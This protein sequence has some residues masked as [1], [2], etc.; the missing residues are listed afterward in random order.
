MDFLHYL[1]TR[2]II[3]E[4][5][6]QKIAGSAAQAGTDVLELLVK[7]GIDK[8]NVLSLKGEFLQIPWRS[9]D[10]KNVPPEVLKYIPEESASYYRFIPIG[11]EDGVL[12]V[13]MVDPDDLP[14]RDALQFIATRLGIPFKIFLITSGDFDALLLNYRGLS[15]EVRRALSEL[16]EESIDIVRK[17]APPPKEPVTSAPTVVRPSSSPRGQGKAKP[18]RDVPAPEALV[19]SR[20]EPAAPSSERDTGPLPNEYAAAGVIKIEK[21]IPEL[22]NGPQAVEEAPITKIVSVVLR[23]A[24][25]GNASDIHIEHTGEQVRVRFRVDGVLY[26]SLLLPK[27]VHNSVVARIK[28][29]SNLKLD[30]RRKPQDG[31]F[32]LTFDDR[33]IDFRVSTFPAYFGEKLVLR[34]LDPEKGVKKLEET[35]LGESDLIRV[36]TALMRP[37]GLIL[38]TGPTGSGKSTTLYAMMNE[39]DREKSNVVS[40]EDPVE[41]TISGV[42]QS[43]V[44]PEIDYTF[45]TGLRSIV[46]Q[47]PDIIMV[48]EIRDKETAQLAIQAALTGHLVFS[49]LHTNNAA[50][51]I[52]RLVEMGIE[53]YLIALTLILAIAQRLVPVMCETSKKPMPI[54]GALKASIDKSFEGLSPEIRKKIVIP[55]QVFEAVPSGECPGGTRGRIG[56]FEMFDV[57]KE[58]EEVILKKPSESEMFLAARKKGMLTMREDALLKAFNGVISIQEVNQFE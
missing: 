57:D 21:E 45:A 15:G 53:P 8:E 20:G 56:V 29:L 10:P 2:G 17:A 30:E 12:E 50:G 27:T 49:T 54:E 16:G 13:G 35:G 39:L 18:L 14:A 43:Q 33:K 38:L 11:F 4:A 34:I 46:R 6:R 24:V 28:V 23:H 31:S 44:R 19:F 25:D 48:G 41:Y 3:D 9:V 5:L 55:K 52:P 22:D 37:Y 36:R 1:V 32:N 51:V 40:L 7:A 58:I 42:S 47:D 26:T